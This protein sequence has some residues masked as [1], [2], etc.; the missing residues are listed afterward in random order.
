VSLSGDVA[1]L[2][3]PASSVTVDWYS[4]DFIRVA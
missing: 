4:I 2:A 3:I 1:W